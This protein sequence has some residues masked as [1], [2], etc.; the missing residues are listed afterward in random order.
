G[1]QLGLHLLNTHDNEHVTV[2][3]VRGFV[4]DDVVG[5]MKEAHA[6]SLGTHCKQFLFS[7]SLNP[8]QNENVGVDVFESTIDQIEERNNLSGQPRVIVF[9]EKEGRR[10]AHAV[11]SRIDAETM[12]ARELPFFKNRL[13]EISKELYRE[14]DWK[15]PRGFINKDERDPRNFTLDQWQQAKRM[16]RNAGD[17]KGDI[18]DCWAI[19]DNKMSFEAALKEKGFYLARGDRRG[20]VAVNAINGEVLSLSRYS[21]KKGKDLD[22]RL[23]KPETLPSIDKTNIHIAQEISPKL[24]GFMRDLQTEKQQALAPLDNQRIAARD[25]QRQAR[26]K[27]DDDLHTKQ[28]ADA[29]ERASRLRTGFK[30]LW[31]K[32]RGEYKRIEQKNVLEAQLSIERDNQKREQLIASQLHER[33]TLQSQIV[34]VREEY[35]QQAADLQKDIKRFKEMREPERP[36]VEPIYVPPVSVHISVPTREPIHTPPVI[37]QPHPPAAPPELSPNFNTQVDQ[38]RE[39]RRQEFM[40]QR[41]KEAPPPTQTRDL[42]RG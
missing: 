32:M 29:Q 38:D 15:M 19:S 41:R 5:A 22:A 4:S 20:H 39:A 3:Q 12:T 42:E 40:E 23:G 1:K 24:K 6:I 16:D 9:H 18:Q 35:R 14:H 8:P 34:Q 11:W 37:E 28:Q 30:G 7:V 36:A 31:H 13:Q 21:G 33:Q 17:L 2:H 10:H 27:L 25:Q 26:Q